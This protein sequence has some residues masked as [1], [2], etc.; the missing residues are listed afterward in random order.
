M[1]SATFRQR[2]IDLLLSRHSFIRHRIELNGIEPKRRHWR[3]QRTPCIGRAAEW[4]AASLA[5]VRETG[6]IS[7]DVQGE[8]VQPLK[9]LFAVSS[10]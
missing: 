2:T 9:R 7:L 1:N 3:C 5:N 8:R 10:G 4:T 6:A